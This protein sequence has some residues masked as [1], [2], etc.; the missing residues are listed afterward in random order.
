MLLPVSASLSCHRPILPLHVMTLLICHPAI[1]LAYFAF[2]TGTLL[3]KAGREQQTDSSWG[4][5]QWVPWTG[6]PAAAFA[7]H[8]QI[9]LHMHTWTGICVLYW[10]RSQFG[11]PPTS[12]CCCLHL[13]LCAVVVDVQNF[14]GHRDPLAG[15][16]LRYD[17][18][19]LRSA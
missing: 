17:W 6:A 16:R 2:S 8:G 7:M 12:A 11:R 18:R 14:L 19:V 3:L 5:W 4:L 13:L 9:S 15:W 10:P 1:V